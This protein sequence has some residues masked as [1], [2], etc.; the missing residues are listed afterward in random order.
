[1]SMMEALREA[2]IAGELARAKELAEALLSEGATPDEIFA[3]AL[4]PAME[5]V[6]RR[7]QR[8]EYYIPEVL[9]SAKAMKG[10]A[11]VLKPAITAAG[12]TKRR[13]KVVTGTV[14]GDL[15]DIGKNLVNMMLEGAGFEVIDL[16]TDVSAGKFVE[17]VKQARP[18]VLGMSALLT[19]TMLEMPK[20][21]EALTQEGLR[22]RVKVMVG[23][24]PLNQRFAE[25]MGADAFGVDASSAVEFAKA[26]VPVE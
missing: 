3:N 19:T 9:I 18:Q 17:A 14:K 10:A 6:G 2:V 15:H 24:A 13:G 1:M 12:G 25:E 5:E 21:V 26:W 7:M 11:E 4:S 22:S 16:G 8:S 23:G 20:V